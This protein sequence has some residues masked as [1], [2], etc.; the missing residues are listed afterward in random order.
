MFGNPSLQST[1]EFKAPKPCEVV[2]EVLQRFFANLNGSMKLLRSERPGIS[3][4]AKVVHLLALKCGTGLMFP[5]KNCCVHR[6]K[7]AR[8]VE[9]KTKRSGSRFR[10]RGWEVAKNMLTMNQTTGKAIIQLILRTFGAA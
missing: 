8:R 1:H 2:C 4:L 3:F 5:E 10:G 7:P 6:L 9:T